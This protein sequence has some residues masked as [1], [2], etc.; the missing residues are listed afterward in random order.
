MRIRLWLRAAQQ[1]CRDVTPDGHN[2]Y[3]YAYAYTYAYTYTY[4][5]AYA[6]A[7]TYADTN[8][9]TNA[10]AGPRRGEVDSDC[11]Q[12]LDLG[13]RLLP[14]LQDRQLRWQVVDQLE[15]DLHVA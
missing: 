11:D 12:G 4:T 9:N 6:H 5:Y 3:A 8:T 1:H 13:Q 7:Y 10:Y 2:A 15:A 14:Q